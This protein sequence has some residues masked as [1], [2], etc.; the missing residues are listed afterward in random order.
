MINKCYELW[1]LNAHDH[2]REELLSIKGNTEAIIDR[3]YK[4]IEFGTGGM[5]GVLG[6]GTNRVNIHTIRHV[7]EGLARQIESQGEV[8]KTRGVVIAYDTR[9]FSQIFAHETARVLALHGIQS[10]IFTESR[11]TPELSFAVRY[12]SSVAGVVITASHNP[13]QYNGFKVYDENGAQLTPKSVDEIVGHMN[14]INNIFDIKTLSEEELIASN[15]CMEI[16]EKLDEAYDMAL[17]TLVQRK[18]LI[19]D[20]HIVYTPLHGAGVKPMIRALKEAGFSNVHIVKEQAI[21]DGTFPTILYPNPEDVDAFELAIA[22]GNEVAADILFATDPDADRLGV[23]VKNAEKYELLTGNQL[24]ALLLHYILSSMKDNGTLPQNG[25]ILKTIVTSELGTAIANKFNVKTVNTLTGFKYIA[26]KIAEYEKSGELSFLFG[27]EESYGYLAGDFVRDKDA[28]QIALLTAEMTVF[29]Q[30][31]GKTII[32]A[33]NDLYSQYGYYE[34]KLLS[35]M[36]EGIEGQQKIANLMKSFRGNIPK[37][38]MDLAVV[39]T[40]DYE[41]S[42][43]KNLDGSEHSI[44]LPKSN[45]IKF[46]LED[47]SW[48]C[49]RPSGTEPKCKIYLSV[50]G[51]NQFQVEQKLQRLVTEAETLVNLM[52]L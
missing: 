52:D 31:Q 48:V 12:L 49:I 15:L 29:Y 13:K 42:I 21:Q 35:F 8:A 3:F 37:K 38:F 2:Y 18:G 33:L 41:R 28:I 47:A 19:K 23:A 10:Y 50:Q 16:S 44:N 45:V 17:Q 4:E 1:I 22:L 24:G 27:Y 36:F 6:A 51:E 20:L 46:I 14:D 25:V 39:R 5:R 40:E 43:A 11:P 34:E 32:E 9:E 7:A 30:E 26:E